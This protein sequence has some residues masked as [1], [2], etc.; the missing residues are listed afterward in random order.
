MIRDEGWYHR[1]WYLRI[2]WVFC[3]FLVSAQISYGNGRPKELIVDDETY[4]A[5][6][7]VWNFVD[8][9][10]FVVKRYSWG[11]SKITDGSVV[12]D[13]RGH[14][15]II[16]APQM[17]RLYVLAVEKRNNHTY[18]LKVK[19]AIG[20][21]EFQGTVML[22]LLDPTHLVIYESMEPYNF[23]DWSGPKHPLK[24]VSGP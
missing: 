18:A 13:L 7:G 5:I 4:S 15:A 21:T 2:L 9:T 11:D 19:D 10:H 24:K 17:G 22:D 16:D 14:P 3:A 23:F 1:R 6:S 20:E 8:G 12:I